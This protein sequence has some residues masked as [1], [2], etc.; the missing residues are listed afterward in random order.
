MIVDNT[1][2]TLQINLAPTDLPHAQYILPHQL[3]QW[4]DQVD[5]ILLILD[6]HRSR[7]RYAEA[8]KERLPGMRRLIDE[9][10]AKYE[11]ARVLDV[12]YSDVV[13]TRLSERYFGGQPIPVK[14]WNG[15]PFYAYFFG[16]DAARHDYI[17]HMDSDIMYGG[18]SS[19]WLA[20]AIQMLV[21]RQDV[22]ACSPLPGPPTSDG[23]LRSQVL[24]PEPLPTLAFR[25]PALSTRLFLLDRQ[26]FFSRIEHL[27]LTQPR[28]RLVWQALADGNPPYDCA[29]CIFS[30]AMKKHSLLRID[31]LGNEPGMW[32]LHPPYRSKLFYD[33]LPS[34][35]EQ[36]ETGNI[37]E[38]QR[39]C[40][41]INE[42]MVDWSSA[43]KS[44]W[45]RTVK[46]ANLFWQYRIKRILYR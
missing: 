2:V 9:C 42:S 12:D 28:R 39:G 7:G 13:V 41:D 40:H 18:G 8:W 16:L 33:L 14:D 26:R 45:Q 43:R 30:R 10:C 38:A 29:E 4:A 32:A 37:P 17:L 21:E 3:R 6:L 31:F 27:A 23:H 20:E 34:L 36:I 5:E 1:N 15:A 22:L 44:L 19:T 24:E 11:N 25:A 35:I 46:H